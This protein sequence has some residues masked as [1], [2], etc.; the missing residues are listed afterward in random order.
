MNKEAWV[1]KAECR[2]VDTNIFMP[3]KH[4]LM[5]PARMKVAL[6]FC[7]RCPV[8]EECLDYGIENNI[9][10]GVYGGMSRKQRRTE[11]TRRKSE[12]HK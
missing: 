2:G 7:N 1:E 10:T 4:G 3:N 12:L 6:E 5:T 8:R 9:V 11:N